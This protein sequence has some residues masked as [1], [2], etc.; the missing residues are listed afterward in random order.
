MKATTTVSMLVIHCCPAE[1]VLSARAAPCATLASL[2][3]SGGG[4]GCRHV[5]TLA[6]PLVRAGVACG[7]LLLSNVKPSGLLVSARRRA[8]LSQLPEQ[9]SSV[10]PQRLVPKRR[11]RASRAAT[12]AARAA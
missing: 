4:S 3:R 1:A 11:R 8:K 9:N 10:P 2:Q 5:R 7:V 12:R 6:A